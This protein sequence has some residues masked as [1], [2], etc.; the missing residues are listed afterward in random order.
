MIR[1]LSG[2]CDQPW[3]DPIAAKVFEYADDAED[4]DIASSDAKETE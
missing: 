4:A 2:T 1:F 3:V